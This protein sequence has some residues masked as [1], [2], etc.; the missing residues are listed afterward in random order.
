MFQIQATIE[1]E[2]QMNT[3]LGL[4]ARGLSDF[5]RP[6]QQVNSLL[7]HTFDLNF[8]SRGALFGGWQERKPQFGPGG[9]RVDTWPLLEKT[10]AMRSQF[11]SDFQGQN[12]L[13]I[14]NGASYFKYHQSNQPRKRLPRRIMMMLDKERIDSIVKIFQEYISTVARS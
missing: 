3:V 9:V 1:G 8:D 7:L 5:S 4:A 12:S 2:E 13:T 6:L 14:T 10:G 11:R